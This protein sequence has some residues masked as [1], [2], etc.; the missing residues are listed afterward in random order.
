MVLSE[1]NPIKMDWPSDGQRVNAIVALIEEGFL[2]QILISSDMCRKHRLW[3]YG[4]PGY[5]HI[6]ENVV[7]LM[8]EKGVSEEHI[9]TLLVEN[10]KRL[11][12]FV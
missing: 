11:L 5:A 12:S 3:H 4:G 8:R 9:H 10:P 2:S 1:D 7:P 6:L